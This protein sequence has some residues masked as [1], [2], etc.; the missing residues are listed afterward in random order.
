VTTASSICFSWASM[1]GSRR[2]FSPRCKTIDAAL[3]FP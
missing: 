3:R 2:R 1:E